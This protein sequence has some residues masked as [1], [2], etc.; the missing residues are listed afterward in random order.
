MGIGPFSANGRRLRCACAVHRCGVV[1]GNLVMES[2]CCQH[3]PAILG[4]QGGLHSSE[5]YNGIAEGAH[6][7]GGSD[8]K[9]QP[10][11]SI[12]VLYRTAKLGLSSV[13]CVVLSNIS[14][15][16]VETRFSATKFV[17]E[18]EPGS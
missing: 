13:D 11:W 10:W 18:M 15:I 9:I 8:A 5:S 14:L 17:L 16:M 6:F 7:V 12:D 3:V 4:C 2:L 1:V